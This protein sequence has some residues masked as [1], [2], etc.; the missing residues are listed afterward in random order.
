[1]IGAEVKILVTEQATP[2]FLAVALERLAAGSMKAP[3]VPLALIAEGA[4]PAEVT[5]ALTRSVAITM[6]LATSR[7]A[8]GC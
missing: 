3:R 1:M 8:D 5:L 4:L 7:G 2:A 6:R